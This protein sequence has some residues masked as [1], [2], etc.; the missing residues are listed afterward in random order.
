MRL[1]DIMLAALREATG[2]DRA[3]EDAHTRA[4]WALGISDAELEAEVEQA[5]RQA[6]REQAGTKPG[7]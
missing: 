7:A 6:A 1:I 3:F 4:L 5:M 2:A